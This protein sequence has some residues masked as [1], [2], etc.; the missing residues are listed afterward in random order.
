MFIDVKELALHKV[1]LRKSY[2]PG[3][4]D[5]HSGEFRQIEPLEVRATAEL[6]DGQIRLVGDLR[7]RLEMVCSRCLEPVVEEISRDFDLSYRPMAGIS[8]EEELRLKTDD[9]EIGFF[10]GDG[11]F[12]A[13]VL[14]EQVLLALPMKVICRSDCRGLCPQCGANLN[15]EECRCEAH[16]ADPRL[17]VLG[18]LKQNWQK[19]H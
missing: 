18:R 14:A 2:A 16:A 5:F 10:E 4:L 12:L 7:T 11:L 13:D 19:K 15:A 1:Q 9:T 6:L 17:A 3:T 8:R